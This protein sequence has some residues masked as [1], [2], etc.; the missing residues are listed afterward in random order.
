MNDKRVSID[1][2]KEILPVLLKRLI[3]KTIEEN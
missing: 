3:M 2:K 1:Y